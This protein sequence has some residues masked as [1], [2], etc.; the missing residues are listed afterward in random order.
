MLCKCKKHFVSLFFFLYL[1]HQSLVS[2]AYRIL[3]NL[4]RRIHINET[5]VKNGI[6]TFYSLMRKHTANIVIRCKHS[7]NAYIRQIFGSTCFRD[8]DFS[9]CYSKL[10]FGWISTHVYALFLINL[11]VCFSCYYRRL[12]SLTQINKLLMVYLAHHAN[13]IK[14]KKSRKPR[15]NFIQSHF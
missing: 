5:M 8:S 6:S 10:H 3:F 14:L 9:V 1:R 12:L 15:F 7:L 4:P 2:Y 11:F 13:P